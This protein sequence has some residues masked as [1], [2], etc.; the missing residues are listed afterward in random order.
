MMMM[1]TELMMR[2]WAYTKE[3]IFIDDNAIIHAS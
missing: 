2:G 1:M 3:Y